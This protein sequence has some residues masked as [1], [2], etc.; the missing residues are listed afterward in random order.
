MKSNRTLTAGIVAGVALAVAAITY[1]QPFAGMGAGFGGGMGMGSGHG[2]M[3]GADPAAMVDSRLADLKAQ[4]KITT[5]QEAAWQAFTGAAKQQATSMH[6]PRVRMQEGTETAPE[7]MGQRTELMQQHTTAMTTMTDAFDALY[8]MLTPEQKAIAD[9][10]FGMMGPH[11][12]RFGPH[13]S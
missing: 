10:Q 2:P 7:R 11:A 13:T 12:M 6:G 8:A 4:L 9:Q 5:A 1:A 3:A